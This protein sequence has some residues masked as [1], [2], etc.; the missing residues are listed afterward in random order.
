MQTATDKLCNKAFALLSDH[1]PHCTTEF[2]FLVP[3][4]PGE[5][6][7]QRTQRAT[8]LLGRLRANLDEIGHPFQLVRLSKRG[9]RGVYRLTKRKVKRADAEEQANENSYE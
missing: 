1:A 4:K 7:W 8:I 3:L 9:E 5:M 2:L 6:H